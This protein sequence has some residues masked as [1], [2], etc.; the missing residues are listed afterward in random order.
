MDRYASRLTEHLRRYATDLEIR[1]SG[2]I[3]SLTTDDSPRNR[4]GPFPIP[5]LPA[6]GLQEARRYFSRYLRYPRRVRAQQAELVHVLD[7]SYAHVLRSVRRV[8]TV[9]TVHDLLPVL[10]VERGAE[11][12]RDR[13]RNRLLE[14][15]LNALRRADA[16]IVATEW[17]RGELGNWLG[18]EERIH[19]I[20]YGVDDGF[21]SGSHETREETRKRLDIP[22]KAFVVLHV[23]SVGPRKNLAAVIAAVHGL[24]A[25]GMDAWLL[26]VGGTLTPD[27]KDDL[28][29]RG[30]AGRVRSVGEAAEPELRSAYR[31]SDVLLFPSHYE[32]FGFPVLEAMASEIPVVT[33]G[34]G[35]LAEVAGDAAIVVGG[36]EVE[37]YDQPDLAGAAHFAGAGTG[38]PVS[39]GGDRSQNRGSLPEPAMTKVQSAACRVQSKNDDARRFLCESE[40]RITGSTLHSA[41]CTLH[42][43]G[44]FVEPLP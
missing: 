19:V 8:P 22:Q 37:P 41:R 1:L 28:A 27:Q 25:S 23:G 40:R 16:W 18:H 17:M 32:G 9:I 35:G 10:T 39:L 26:Q 15:V 43:F 6:P 21:F 5:L 12:I 31:A 3:A 38:P 44:A 14:W 42:A 30:I 34:A 11:R 13:I 4:S 29:A 33:S 2:Q 7:H 24:R 20:P 36:R